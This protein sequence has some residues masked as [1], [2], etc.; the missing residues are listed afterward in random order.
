MMRHHFNRIWATAAI[1]VVA[2]PLLLSAQVVITRPSRIAASAPNGDTLAE[3]VDSIL[4][5]TPLFDRLFLEA[6]NSQMSG[7]DST[8]F[9]LLEHCRQL[10]PDAAEVYFR[11]S[12]IYSN[13][14]NDTLA[15][16]SLRRAAELQPSNDTY[17]ESVAETFICQ[18]D[19][20][21]AIDAYE[22]L[23]AHHHD[24]SDVLNVLV[25]LYGATGDY[26]H[27]LSTISRM[28]QADGASDEL[29]MM[30]MNVY[31]AQG[32]TKNAY[33]I[34]KSLADN[35]PYEPHYSVMLGNWL[36][37][38]DR[39]AEAYK[40]FMS[41]LNEDSH[42]EFALNSLYD[43]YRTTGD[44]A[45]AVKLRNDILFNTQTA[46]KTKIS[47][48]Q[49]AIRESESERGG[50]S[51][52]VLN[53]LNRTIASAPKN[54]DISNMKVAY[55][56]IKH[57]PADSIIAACRHTLAFAPDNAN[58]RSTMLRVYWDTQ[59][60]DEMQEGSREGTLYNPDNIV[61]YYLLGVASMQKDDDDV[62]L[63][64]FQRGVGE[65]ND[66]EDS[67][68]VGDMYGCIGDISYNKGRKEEAFAA[69]DSALQWRPDN[70]SVLNN[71]A[72]YLSQEKRDL[73][74][75]AEMSQKTIKADPTN[76]T[77]LD[78]YA[79]ILFLQKRYDEAKAYI[80]LTLANDASP[81][82]VELEHAG[83]IYLCAGEA[84]KAVEFWNKAL[85]A[86]GDKKRLEKKIKTRKLQ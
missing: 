26:D 75:A 50:D 3:S 57:M 60:W 58:A 18:R 25:G 6:V 72:Y 21:R 66:K 5:A 15:I 74:R 78:T 52:F 10:R 65:A 40:L 54:A 39:K 83:D 56:D 24:R 2:L 82:D 46:P 64:A 9:A 51:I 43:Y 80:D 61:F 12:L 23:Y 79:W 73:S 11:E 22:K 28:E 13:R 44:T 17:Q 62:A 1:V 68:I 63:D 84:E 29:S 14:G 70:N 8:A 76:A 53:L 34:L 20:K 32:D 77:F 27:L 48:L 7:N 55:M 86:G 67:D 42:N 35:H 33:R 36:M 16:E 59:R 69:Y 47:M 37:Q 81:S 71:Y 4:A 49:Q 85:N 45:S 31:E 38:H 41:A 30:R 19:Y